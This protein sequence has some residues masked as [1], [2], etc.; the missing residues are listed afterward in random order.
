MY[1]VLIQ[2]IS[3][4]FLI[5]H[6]FKS[7][8]LLS[9][10]ILF[11]YTFFIYQLI[12]MKYFKISKQLFALILLAFAVADGN[13]QDSVTLRVQPKW[14]FGVSGAANIN[15]YRGT[16]QML[17]NT[18]YAP[19]TFHKGKG[20]KPYASFLIEYKPNKVFGL[21]LNIAYDGRGGHFDEVIAPCN[22]PANLATNLSYIAIEPSLRIAP[23]ASALYVFIGPTIGI[24]TTKQFTYSQEKQITTID[25]WSSIRKTVIAAQAGVGIDIPVSAKTSET[26]MVI[27]PFAS[28]QT[29]LFDAPRSV[30]TWTNNTVRA[31][32]ALK[33]GTGKKTAKALKKVPPIHDTLYKYIHD[34]V[35][36]KTGNVPPKDVSFSVRAPKAFPM[37]RQTKETFP[38]R[39]SVFFDKGSN[40]IPKRYITLTKG[41][42]SRFSEQL[43]QESQPNNLNNG[44]RSNRQMAVYYNILNIL[45]DRLTVN[46]SSTINLSGAS[47]NNPPD[48]KQMA[49]NIKSYLVDNFGI[50]AK[51][52]TTEG[53]SRP[54]IPSE[55]TGATKWITL[56]REGDRRVD[57]ISTS[58]E[59]LLQVGG[60]K[61]SFF[62][63]VYLNPTQVNEEDS[64]VIFNVEGAEEV[65]ESWSVEMKDDQ[66]N[67]QYYGPYK[68]NRASVP[69][70][71]ILGSNSQGNYTV[72]LTGKTKN[73]NTIT[74]DGYVSLTKIN[75]PK[76]KGLRYS[77]LFDFDKSTTIASYEKFLVEV[78]APLIPDNST[79]M[80]HGHTDIIGDALYNKKLSTERATSTQKILENAQANKGRKNVKFN[81]TG[82]GENREEAPFDNALPEE[83]FYNRT[84]I[85]DIVPNK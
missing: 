30:E 18:L 58:P 71:T 34:T 53:R 73:G 23:F 25:N 65:L 31:G 83:R 45:G 80:I 67:K 9:R 36:V 4:D 77:I 24:N 8:P 52:I 29:D 69:A 27:A 55:Q 13:A 42:A 72:K 74:K 85:I 39:N 17:N 48:G 75:N 33:F 7:K 82:Y 3:R 14:W 78:V 84:V 20:V 47:E 79:V 15:T 6:Y 28:F 63:P 19:T 2:V 49:E 1:G 46:P 21:M 66:N 59:L 22:C 5:L 64:H 16:T 50:D 60:K 51:R 44:D 56:L 38:I 32:I 76:N 40:E 11:Q 70:N 26:Q 12:I 41:E 68:T 35:T 57:I 43:L 81:A 37:N 62:K 61:S 10:N 54:I